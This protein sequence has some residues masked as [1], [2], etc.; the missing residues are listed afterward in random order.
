MSRRPEF[1]T[2]CHFQL[3][4]SGKLR[5]GAKGKVG[6]SKSKNRRH[7]YDDDDDEEDEDNHRSGRRSSNI[8]KG[9]AAKSHKP[10]HKKAPTKSKMQLMPWGQSPKAKGSKKSGS[11]TSIRERLEAVAKTGQ[12]AYKDL[13]RKAKVRR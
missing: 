13:Y 9:K 2:I 11:G 7:T 8:K 5:G 4:F 6:S 3:N 10:S 1:F 12:A